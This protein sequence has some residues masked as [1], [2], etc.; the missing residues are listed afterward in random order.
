MKTLAGVL[1][2]VVGLA[3]A[4]A[5]DG[6]LAGTECNTPSP[7]FLSGTVIGGLVVNAGDFCFLDGAHISGG[8]QVNAGGILIACGSTINGG[9]V[10]N[11]A[12]TVA[13]GPE[14]IG[15]P[16]SVINGGV[17]I[18][19]TGGDNFPAGPPSVALE[20]SAIHG[21]VRLIGNHGHIAVAGN[22]IAGGLFCA[23]NAF[24]LEDEGMTNVVTGP[25]RCKFE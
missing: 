17:Q 19:N 23:N 14:E 12:A 16:G 10:A 15:C 18:S 20:H 21:A 2:W 7:P 9:I 11:G 25:I 4:V 1:V 22:T 13:I 6:A 5:S 8:V 24:D 3:L